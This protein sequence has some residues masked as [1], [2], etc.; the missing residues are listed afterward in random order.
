MAAD[1][2]SYPPSQRR[3]ARL[4]ALGVTPASGALVAATALAAGAACCAIAWPSLVSWTQAAIIGT[5]HAATE[6]ETGADA[7]A[8]ARGIFIGPGVIVAAIGA[9]VAV[10]AIAV[11]RVQLADRGDASA[12]APASESGGQ[13]SASPAQTGWLALGAA[14]ALVAAAVSARTALAHAGVLAAADDPAV[15]L[16]AW[17][18]M[19]A[20]VAWPLLAALVGFGLLDMMMRGAAFTGAAWMSRRE[21]EEELRLTRGP[22]VIRTWRQRRMRRG[23]R[24]A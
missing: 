23:E 22:D 1:S 6:I 10:V 3:L 18:A 9:V 2:R 7:L 14:V 20:A 5:L 13:S 24:D 4:W 8:L 11:H 16:A 12:G 21:M 19:A 15:M 17:R